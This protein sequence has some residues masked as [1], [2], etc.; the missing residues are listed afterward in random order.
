MKFLRFVADFFA[1]EAQV[2]SQ[3][4]SVM[5]KVARTQFFSKYF[6]FFLSTAGIISPM[7][8]SCLYIRPHK[9]GDWQRP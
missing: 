9:L 2:R 5:D 7:L 1:A 6:V 8:H 3:V 4:I